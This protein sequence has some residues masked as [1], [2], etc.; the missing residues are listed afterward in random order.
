MVNCSTKC[1]KGKQ[2]F[3]Q[4]LFEK[5]IFEKLLEIFFASDRNSPKAKSA[6]MDLRGFYN[7]SSIFTLKTM[8]LI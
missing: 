4:L 8:I 6:N 2:V 5:Q 3:E 1:F 7:K